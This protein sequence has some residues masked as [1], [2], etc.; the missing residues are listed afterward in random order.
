M[1]LEPDKANNFGYLE[2]V[3]F[4][5]E[6]Y[7]NNLVKDVEYRMD[8]YISND[9]INHTSQEICYYKD[10]IRGYD[11]K[12]DILDGVNI[13]IDNDRKLVIYGTGWEG[14]KFL[15]NLIADIGEKECKEQIIY[16]ID[17]VHTG[18]FHGIPIYTLENAPDLE[19][20]YV[21]V[22]MIYET[23]SKIITLLEN[24]GLKQFE[25]FIWSRCYQK[26]LVVINANCHG[27]ALKTYL[28]KS[29]NFKKRY[30]IYPMPEIQ[31]N[32]KKCIDDE[33]MN[34]IDL[35]IHQD[36]RVDNSVDYLLSDEY[37]IP[38]LKKECN[39][40]CIPNLVGN[41]YGIFQTQ[42]GEIFSIEVKN[43]SIGKLHLFYRDKL[44]DEA[45]QKY[46]LKTVSRIIDYINTYNFSEETVIEKFNAM[47]KK[48]YQREQ[49]WDIK[50]T[51]YIVE[52]Y[53]TTS[54]FVDCCHPSQELMLEICRR[55]AGVLGIEDIHEEDT[56]IVLGIEAFVWP[57]IRKHLGILWEKKTV[58]KYCSNSVYGSIDTLDIEE[59]IR[60]Y[61][62][63]F[64]GEYLL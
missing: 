44:I 47:I 26:K 55:V 38:R 10:L 5:M 40:L 9:N 6:K 43:S 24:K 1:Y 34:E 54:M 51:D 33:I 20:Y 14:E 57:S 56:S 50:I 49:N 30:C 42:T 62:Y 17:A 16:C 31:D 19:K 58:R 39:T 22:A 60:E 48:L 36:I 53:R 15:Y 13:M 37:I 45:Y 18:S 52:N 29:Q 27:G 61:I 28:E 3:K 35:Y 12:C 32:V 63:A 59:Y 64:W 2:A 41:G 11:K 25:N 4:V 21:I 7:K 23:Y 8:N 46:Q